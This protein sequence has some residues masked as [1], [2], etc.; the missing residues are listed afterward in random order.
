MK[1]HNRY[2]F[3][4]TPGVYPPDPDDV[5]TVLYEFDTEAAAR[6]SGLIDDP[7][8]TT[9]YMSGGKC[10]VGGHFEKEGRHVSA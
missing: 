5:T 8:R 2:R 3:K 7:R 4:G 6:A 10:Y 1:I 9:C